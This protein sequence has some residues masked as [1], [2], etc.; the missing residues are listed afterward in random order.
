MVHAIIIENITYAERGIS[1]FKGEK[2]IEVAKKII[3][4]CY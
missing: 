1:I 3:E 4:V 2:E